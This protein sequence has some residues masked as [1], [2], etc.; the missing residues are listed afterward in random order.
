[1]FPE[2]EVRIV[3]MKVKIFVTKIYWGVY[4]LDCHAEIIGYSFIQYPF[5]SENIKENGRA[6]ETYIKRRKNL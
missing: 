5:L 2:L 4:C 1:M 6:F 3:Q